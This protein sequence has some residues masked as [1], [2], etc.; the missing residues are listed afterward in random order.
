MEQVK[1]GRGLHREISTKVWVKNIL[2]LDLYLSMVL[3]QIKLMG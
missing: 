2:Y 1:N 3:E